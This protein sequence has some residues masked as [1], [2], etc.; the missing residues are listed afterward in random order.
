MIVEILIE[1]GCFIS[2][3][4]DH[5]LILFLANLYF[6]PGKAFQIHMRECI[7]VQASQNL[8]WKAH[9]EYG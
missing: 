8:V 9:I 2:I 6:R 4:E 1:I 7:L 5:S 3:M